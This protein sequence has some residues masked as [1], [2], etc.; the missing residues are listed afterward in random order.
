MQPRTLILGNHTVAV[1]SLYA[2]RRAGVPI[3]GVVCHPPDT[4]D[5]TRYESL[6]DAAESL[7]TPNVIRATPRDPALAELIRAEKPDLLWTVDYRYIL[8][9]TLVDAAP[10][11]GINLHP[12]LLPK[13]RGR[14]PLNWA[15]L[16]GE[17][18]LGLTAHRITADADAGEIL[19]QLEFELAPSEDVGDALKKLYPL[20]ERITTRV[21]TSIA[22]GTLRGTTQ[23]ESQATTF[24]R[25]TPEDGAIDWS[26]PATSIHNLIR[27]V[28]RPYP[29]AF[30]SL[31]GERV[32]IWKSR[33]IRART[34]GAPGEIVWCDSARRWVMTGDG[35]IHVDEITD[36]AGNPVTLRA[37]T[38]FDAGG[39]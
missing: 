25:R 31:H 13:Y 3:V 17:T 32:Y 11:G 1:R 14:A 21:I 18:T 2:L 15:I 23:D 26:A 34:V 24:P 16:R 36:A 29:G 8:P 6:Y 28:A 7:R 27:A 30:T 5:G 9:M 39:T 4:E 37:G 10:L 38:R 22:A 33:L 19:E 20:Y 35:V 12:S